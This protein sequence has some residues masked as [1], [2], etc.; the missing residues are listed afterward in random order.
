M[1]TQLINNHQLQEHKT[2]LIIYSNHKQHLYISNSYHY[3]NSNFISLS[4]MLYQKET[5]FI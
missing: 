4:Y 5:L 2:K 1:I 3:I